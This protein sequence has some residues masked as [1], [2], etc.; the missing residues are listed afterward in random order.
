MPERGFPTG[1]K[2]VRLCGPKHL[3]YLKQNLPPRVSEPPWI[4]EIY[5]FTL[6][7]LGRFLYGGS[8]KVLLMAAWSPMV[9]LYG[10]KHISGNS[11]VFFLIAEVYGPERNLV[12]TSL[13][14]DREVVFARFCATEPDPIAH[15]ESDILLRVGA[16]STPLDALFAPVF[17][18]LKAGKSV[19]WVAEDYQLPDGTE[20]DLDQ[21]LSILKH[22]G[23]PVLPVWVTSTRGSPWKL[24]GGRWFLGRLPGGLN[25]VEIQVGHPLPG[26]ADGFHVRDQLEKL[27]Y[28]VAQRHISREIPLHRQFVRRAWETPKN[29]FWV[30]QISGSLSGYK[31]LTG[32]YLFARKLKPIVSR[33]EM[34]GVWLPTGVG[35]ALVNTALAFLGKVSINLNYTASQDVALACLKQT[36]VKTVIT[37]K[38]FL[39]RMPFEPGPGRKLVFLED[40]RASIGSLERV[41]GGFLVKVCPPWLF[42]RW[43]MPMTHHKISDLATIIFS[44]GS[45]GDPKGVQLTQANLLSNSLAVIQFIRFGPGDV[46]LACLPFFHSFGYTITLCAPMLLGIKTVYHADPRQ[47]KEIGELAR[48]HKTTVFLSTATFLRFCLRRAQPGDFASLWLIVCGA[49]KLPVPLAKEF[50]QKHGVLPLEGYGCTELAPVATL[51]RPDEIEEGISWLRNRPGTIGRALVGTFSAIVDPVNMEIKP[52]GEEG[53]IACGGQ[54]VMKGY[55]HQPQKTAEVIRHGMYLTGDMG[56]LDNHRHITITG[57]LTRFAKI[58]GEMV[59]LEKIE[60]LLHETVECTERLCAVTCV[61]DPSRGEKVVIVY[62]AEV[63]KGL[64][65]TKSQWLGLLAKT[66]IPPL[67]RPDERDVFE[68]AEIPSLGSGKLD[69]R[70]VKD[71]AHTLTGNG[72]GG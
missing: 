43:L 58:A 16:V 17:A 52:M 46:M 33:E 71:L 63:L 13:S 31:A 14:A 60:E 68:V 40:I 5:G 11:P 20:V 67:W 42:E 15:H 57:R 50:Q 53:M 48:L 4:L 30:D 9:H 47:A 69:I 64:G 54:N 26:N 36:T 18:A 55:L 44:S 32:S 45:T 8:R 41:W 56:F 28:E 49:E 24:K 70:H 29:E 38:R 6:G 65:V 34:V 7:W 25:E 61:P 66:G 2:S 23:V 27:S 37:S 12:R 59:P 51:N 3:D 72:K 62:L 35:G 21:V 22:S 1:V 39:E 19:A 10:Q